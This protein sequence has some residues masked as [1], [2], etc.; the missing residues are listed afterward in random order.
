[1]NERLHEV[2][3]AI[4]QAGGRALLVGGCVRDGLLG[5]EGGD[6]DC[7]VHGLSQPALREILL[8]FGEVN[9]DGEA[10]GVYALPAL[11]ADFALPR[12]ERRTGARHTDFTVE[13]APDLSPA[14]AAARRDFT[15]NAMMRDALTGEL[16]DPYGGERDLAAR[17]LRAVPGGQFEED[18][19]RVLRGAQFAARFGLQVEPGTLAA[20]RRMPV[21]ALSG[22]R[23][24][25]EMKKAL[26]HAPQPDVFFRVLAQA[27]ALEPWFAEVNALRGVPQNPIYHPEG[28]AFEHTMLVVREAAALRGEVG[29]GFMLAALTHD[30]GKAVTT[31]LNDKG[32]WASIGHETAGVP[33]VNALL[34]RLCAGKQAQAYC[35][36]LCRLHMRVHTCYYQKARV[37]RT[38]LLF[39]ACPWPRDLALLAVCDARGTGK[40]RQAADEEEAFV[41]E[42]LRLY[43]KAASRPMPTGDMLIAAGAKPGPGMKALLK[44]AR[45]KTLLG[46]RA[47][48]AALQAARQA[49]RRQE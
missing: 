34:E 43:E 17:V 46:M 1:M 38:H 45:E 21:D 14:Q 5:R 41:M 18:P 29:E 22:P 13:L 24:F 32:A 10:F 9:R 19:L 47:Q 42:R 23:V 15:V 12:R 36:S 25:A 8:R 40:P 39:D 37:S 27:D 2:A 31:R 11:H 6:I 35:A 26:L 16:I 48:E 20:M 33:L 7:E 49:D 30:L 4:A 3:R 28:D 44:Q